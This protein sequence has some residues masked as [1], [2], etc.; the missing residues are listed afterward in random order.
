V[1]RVLQSAHRL[2]RLA[3]HPD[4]DAD[5]GPAR[6]RLVIA[7]PFIIG[8]ECL[9]R[10][11]N[12]IVDFRIVVFVPPSEIFVAVESKAGNDSGPVKPGTPIGAVLAIGKHQLGVNQSIR[13]LGLWIIL[14]E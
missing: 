3:H 11:G 1:D 4:A 6:L 5:E 13:D 8:L 2:L 7:Q 9:N 12:C 14:G 10:P